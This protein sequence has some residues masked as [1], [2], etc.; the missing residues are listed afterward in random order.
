[1]VPYTIVDIYNRTMWGFVVLMFI[2]A[3]IQTVLAGWEGNCNTKY[4]ILI[5]NINCLLICACSN[6]PDAPRIWVIYRSPNT[7]LWFMNILWFLST[8]DTLYQYNVLVSY[9]TRCIEMGPSF[10][11][12]VYKPSECGINLHGANQK[13]NFP[14][15]VGRMSV[16][17]ME[18]VKFVVR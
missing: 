13:R 10:S 8:T 17:F 11:A 16:S 1:M 2:S 5:S 7:M 9:W 6:I 15:M 4:I 14:V 18:N 12:T 3:I